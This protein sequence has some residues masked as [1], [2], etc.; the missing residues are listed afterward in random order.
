MDAGKVFGRG[1]AFPPRIGEDGRLAWSE[2]PENVRESI[3]IIL[4]TELGERLML[5]EFGAGLGAYLFEPNTATTRRLIQE[6]ISDAL[7][8]WEPRV[9]V[10][11][12]TVEEDPANPEAAIATISYQ[13]V[14]NQTRERVTLSVDLSAGER[15]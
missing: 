12:I 13:L 2:G 15:G 9:K 7:A 3:R 11:G 14:A 1:I 4:M 8:R 5:P 6:R 10:E